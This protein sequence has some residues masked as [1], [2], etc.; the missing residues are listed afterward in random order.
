MTVIVDGVTHAGTYFVQNEMVY[1]QS[2]VGDKSAKVGRSRP[3]VV[4]KLLL[5]EL[6]RAWRT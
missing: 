5:S 3:E 1:V 2:S 4:A 6:V